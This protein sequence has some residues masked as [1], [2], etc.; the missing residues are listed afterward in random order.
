MSRQEKFY[1]ELGRKVRE[2]AELFN[3]CPYNVFDC[4]F[5]EGLEDGKDVLRFKAHMIERFD[6]DTPEKLFPDIKERLAFTLGLIG[7]DLKGG[8]RLNK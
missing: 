4:F 5:V 1:N 8:K 3:L 6:L 7:R 2:S